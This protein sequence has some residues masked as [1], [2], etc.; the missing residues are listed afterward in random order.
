MIHYVFWGWVYFLPM[1]KVKCPDLNL[2]SQP[3]MC[4]ALLILRCYKVDEKEASVFIEDVKNAAQK[5]YGS[6]FLYGQ[7]Q[8]GA[9]YLPL[10]EKDTHL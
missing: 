5:T 1:C 4:V 2:V 9:H 7:V 8:V 6:C 3:S 10:M